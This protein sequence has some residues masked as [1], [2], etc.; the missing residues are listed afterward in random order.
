MRNRNV[1]FE[2]FCERIGIFG[3]EM[4]MRLTVSFKRC[5]VNQI[6]VKYFPGE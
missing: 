1:G 4:I 5:S 2:L 3:L 6:V